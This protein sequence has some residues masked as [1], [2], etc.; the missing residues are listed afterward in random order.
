M[1]EFEPARCA[2]FCTKSSLLPS[3]SVSPVDDVFDQM[4]LGIDHERG[5]VARPVFRSGPEPAPVIAPGIRFLLSR[6]NNTNP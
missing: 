1:A 4:S 2:F 3:L 6:V 5:I